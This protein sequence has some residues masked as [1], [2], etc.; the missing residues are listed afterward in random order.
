MMKNLI[1][2]T[3]A[4]TLSA[5]S[6]LAGADSTRYNLSKPPTPHP[7]EPSTPALLLIAAGLLLLRIRNSNN[8]TFVGK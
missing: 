8:D 2:L 4:L 7:Y 6:N 5:G 1:L 3:A